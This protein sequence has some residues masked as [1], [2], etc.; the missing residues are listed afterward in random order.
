[1]AQSTDKK[2]AIDGT[3]QMR[4]LLDKRSYTWK[5]VKAVRRDRRNYIVRGT[6]AYQDNGEEKVVSAAADV[7]T[8][9]NGCVSFLK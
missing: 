1:M 3:R 4:E 2:D 5:E 6:L 8:G 7:I 9:E